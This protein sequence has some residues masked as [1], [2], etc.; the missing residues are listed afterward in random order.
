MPNPT[1]ITTRNITRNITCNILALTQDLLDLLL[2][3]AFP[4]RS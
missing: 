2:R 1:R 3:V 4:T